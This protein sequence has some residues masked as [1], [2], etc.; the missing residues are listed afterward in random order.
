M[1]FLCDILWSEVQSRSDSSHVH[2]C[3]RS[4]FCMWTRS[5]SPCNVMHSPSNYSSNT[6]QTRTKVLLSF[7]VWTMGLTLLHEMS[8]PS[9]PVQ[10]EPKILEVDLSIFTES[11]I[12]TIACPVITCAEQVTVTFLRGSEEVD[13]GTLDIT[14]PMV[15]NLNLMVASDTSGTYACKVD[16]VNPT[17]SVIQEFNITGKHSLTTV[18]TRQIS[19]NPF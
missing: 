11:D 17:D 7:F 4:T 6:T 16:T 5:G 10:I 18:D 13:M 3:K 8:F 12:A 2:A 9:A 15:Y 19:L 1:Y 14:Q